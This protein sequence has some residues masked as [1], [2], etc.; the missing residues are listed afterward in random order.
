MTESKNIINEKNTEKLLSDLIRIYSPYFEEENIMEFVHDWLKERNIPVEYHHYEDDKVTKFKGV[1]VIGELKGNKSGKKVLING[2]MDSVQLCEGWTKDPL[3]P[4]VEEGRMYGL[5]S[6]DMKSGSAAAMMAIE[7][8]KNAVPDFDGS[9][10]YHF[11][12]DE[13]GPYG[14]GT[15]FIIHDNLIPDVDVAIVPEPSAGFTGVNFPCLCLGARGGYSYTVEFTGKSAHAANPQNGICAIEAASK[16]IMELKKTELKVD[17]YLGTGDICVIDMNGGGAACS[18][19]DKASFTV[20]RH[21]V[22]GEDKETIKKELDDAVKAADI[23]ADYEIKFREAPT[24]DS[25]GFL[26][27]RVDEDNEYSVKFKESIKSV[28]DKD[29]EIAYFQSIGDFCYI[30]SRLNVPTLVFGPGG[31]NYHG[32]DEYVI[33]EDVIKT[34]EVIYDYLV[35]ILT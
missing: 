10:V 34:A 15:N 9:I 7:A 18:V 26:P 13:E 23:D 30:G 19:A 24:P 8:F 22:M 12:S 1:N 3:D 20:F 31:E 6:L 29:P 21:I 28:T 35:R 27:Y 16:V 2:H 17:P 33:I 5:G 25:D 32:A 14:L 4:V 11:V